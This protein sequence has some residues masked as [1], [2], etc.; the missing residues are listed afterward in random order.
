MI[1]L[2]TKQLLVII[3]AI[4]FSIRCSRA[5]IFLEVSVIGY[6]TFTKE[7]I[8]LTENDSIVNAGN[9]DLQTADKM[10]SEVIVK[11]AV[12]YIERKI[13]RTVV[14]IAN[15]ITSEGSTALEIMKK[16]PGVQ[17]GTDGQISL[18][19]KAGVNVYIDGKPTYLSSDD[20]SNLLNGM[21]A[22]SVQKIEIMT[23]PPAKYDAAGTAG[24]INIIKKK[25]QKEGLN[26]SINAGFGQSYYSRYNTGFSL[27]Y[28]NQQFNLFFNNTYGYNKNLSRRNVTSDILNVN[29]QLVTEQASA[30]SDAGSSSDYRPTLAMD[31]YL[32]KRTTLT[33]SGTAG[34]GVSHN[35]ISSG[36]DILD[37]TLKKTNHINFGSTLNIKPFNYTTGIQLSH[38]FDTT[39]NSINIDI[40]YSDYATSPLQRNVTS[41][42]DANGSFIN[43]ADA[44]LRQHRQLNIYAATADY[45]KPLKN[46]GQFETGIKSS[47]VKAVND[48]TYYNQAGGQT[49]VD[50]T[51]SNYSINDENI[52]AAYV[53]LNKTYHKLSVQAGLRAEQTIAKGKQLLTGQTINQNY[54]QLFPSVFFD[55]VLND[56]NTFN[57]KLSRRTERANYSEMVPFRRPQTATLYFQGNPNLKPQ[58]TWHNEIS[59]SYKNSFSIDFGY[60]INRDYIRTLPFLDSNKTTITRIPTNIRGAHSWNI[61]I[62][63][64]K[65]ILNFWSTDNI[66][67]I[68]Q[69][70]FTG[71]VNGFSLDN[72]GLPSIYL[73]TNNSFSIN[74][75]LSAECN[76]EYNSKRQIVTSTFG[77]YSILSF[78]LKWFILKKKASI[79]INANNVLQTEGHNGIDR[80]R[81]LYQYSNFYFY[82]RSV[83]INFTCRFGRGK[84][85]KAHINSGSEEEQKR[86]GN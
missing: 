72:N 59:W 51:Q 38:Q 44:V 18:N 55:Y 27:S 21:S 85:V 14:N 68:Y 22:S 81:G 3:R 67:S 15:S 35:L 16:L 28:K 45:T 12:P 32:S 65:K 23:N 8:L 37:S 83:S 50:S 82:T 56:K 19:G 13:D 74:D 57:I 20:L 1:Q 17:V 25:N 64:S 47:Y 49:M 70:Y 76:F 80:Y 53:N 10:L 54:F 34:T 2:F 11:S 48:N 77:A 75:E 40:D 39:G 7:N 9:L 62:G 43:E 63:Y 26:G 86:A 79:V 42:Y 61:D 24:I 84:T 66:L 30:N 73:T 29:D 36:M 60:D 58:I 71:M 6:N 33:L 78:G 41:F 46:K 5:T 31:I 69:N 4:S 52:N